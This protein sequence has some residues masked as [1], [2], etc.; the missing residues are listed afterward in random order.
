MVPGLRT[1]TFVPLRSLSSPRRMRLCR[2]EEA[3][4]MVPRRE[5]DTGASR[6]S[7]RS[8]HELANPTFRA[9]GRRR[10]G[11]RV[12]LCFWL[13]AAG[14]SASPSFA[15]TREPVAVVA[16]EAIYEEDLAPLIQG[17]MQQI[18]RQEYEV[19]RQALEE[20][21]NQKLLEAE[22]AKRGLAPAELLRQEVDAKVSPT[23]DA[24]VEA[25]Y[26]AQKDRINRPLAE[27]KGQ[28]QQMLRQAKVEQARETYLRSLRL[29]AEVAIRLRA[30]KVE[31][32]YDSAR[33]RGDPNAPITIIEFSD[34][35]CPFCQ[36]AHPV[37]KELLA[38]YAGQVKVAYR[39]FPLRQIHPQADAA[40]EA[41]RCAGEQGKFWPFHDRLFES[42]RA[43]D[44]AAFAD[45]AAAI[46]LDQARFVDCLAADKFQAQIEQDLQDGTRAGVNGTPGFFIN[47][48]MVTGAQPL[49][50]FEQVV[51]DELAALRQVR[52]AP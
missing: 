8:Q 26:T 36:R 52:P 43:L 13:F 33:V 4:G 17:P 20:L 2:W 3:R 44:L 22:A 28:I 9:K 34:F 18:R 49:A 19:K 45:H 37:V 24:E 23:T 12:G 11:R 51:E 39:D 27:V 50:V 25:V 15:Q 40:A 32:S 6:M 41:A 47:G 16:G 10:L 30:P 48:V 35:Q 7:F 38:K 42:N 31:V 14:W 46:G 5:R 1:G 29:G 21:L